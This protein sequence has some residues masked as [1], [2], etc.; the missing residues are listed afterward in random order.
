M[1]KERFED[2]FSPQNIKIYLKTD[3]IDIDV[4]KLSDELLRGKYIPSPL[5]SFELKKSNNKT[6]EIKILT[7]KDKL[8]QKVLYESINEFFDKQFSNRSYGYRIGKSTIKAIK[9][10]K[11]F[12]KRKYFYVFK[13]DIKNFFENIN[14]NKLISLLDRNIEDKRI[15]RLI[16][17]FIKSGILKKEYFS[18][19]IGVHQ[20]DIL[21]PLLSNIYL[22]EFDKFLESKNIE[23]V[24]YADDFVIFMKKNNKEIPEILNIFLKNI[25]LEISEEK[26]YFSDIYKGFSFLG[27]FFR[28]N[29]V[30]IDKKK[31]YFHIESVKEL[32]NKELNYFLK[33]IENK[34][35]GLA[36]YY[37]KVIT[38]N[39]DIEY[40]KGII[41]EFIIDRLSNELKD[42]S[43][44]ELK[45]KLKN[46][47]LK[48]FDYNRLIDIAYEKNK[49]ETIPKEKIEKQ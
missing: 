39:Q 38:S 35:D 47:N 28:N 37:E 2:I 33:K 22:N 48:I 30:Y 34:I 8:V 6:R 7:D 4:K 15:I 14:H 3:K 32:Q 26:S 12:I 43:K 13:S 16:V 29:D 42:K 11:D 23:F 31:L 24:R 5:Q 17:Q 19:E 45:E 20:G 49:Y 1:F 18:H 44:K 40:L 46:L 41:K 21:S 27:C 9:R 10:C 36:R 25:D